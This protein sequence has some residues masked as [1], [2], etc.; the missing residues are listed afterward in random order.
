[1]VT[2]VLLILTSL[3]IAAWHALGGEQALRD[4]YRRCSPRVMAVA[5]RMLGDRGEAEDVVQETFLE[6]WR[7]AKAYDERRASP[8]TWAVVIARSRAIDRMRARTS[9]RRAHEAQRE[10]PPPS[11]TPLEPVEAREERER[12]LGALAQLPAEQRSAVELAF[13]E[14]LT[15]GEIAARLGQPLGTVKS[16][17]R[18]AM[19]KLEARLSPEDPP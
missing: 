11:A 2:A 4:L 10:D 17:V 9:L 18:L 16:R 3:A 5:L 15:H 12:V 14:G 7:R 6:L 8:A 19:Q 13:F 1:M